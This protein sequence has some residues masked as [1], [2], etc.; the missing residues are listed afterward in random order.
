[1]K[2]REFIAGV[3]STAAWPLAARAQQP[4][5]PVV[6]YLSG[7][8][9]ESD[10][11]KRAFFKGLNEEG[12]V[13]GRNVAIEYRYARHMLSRL[14]E[15][16]A[17]LVRRRVDVLV[18]AATNAGALKSASPSIPVVF[19]MGGDPMALG[20]IATLAR[21]GGNLTGATFLGS[22]A[23]VKMAEALHEAVPHADM[24]WLFNPA[25]ENSE[26]QARQFD[27]AARVLG[28]KLDHLS[29]A[30][31]H[32]IDMAFATL[33]ERHTGALVIQ[34]DA[35]FTDY[36]NQLVVLMLRYGI[37]AIY[38]NRM[39]PEAGGLM[40]YGGSLE[41]A[42]RIAGIYVGRI[43]KGEKPADLPVQQST[44]VE[45][46]INMKTAKALGLTLPLSLLGRAD[47]VIE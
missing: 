38:Q 47:E 3:G 24:A 31:E 42:S 6:G 5:K 41:D 17:D 19:S 34:G 16:A 35:L 36:L 13:E 37:P 44:K 12:F 28:V 39:F 46:I 4:A 22:A 40:S 25:Q 2:R 14:P 18:A 33:V 9:P 15:L 27:E 10:P 1:M 23:A 20:L 43:L 7:N 45:L 21:P 8:T 26:T 11:A 32:D 29:A 30:N